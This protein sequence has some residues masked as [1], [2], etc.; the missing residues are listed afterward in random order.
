MIRIYL[1]LPRMTWKLFA[2][3]A[4][5][6]KPSRP[7]ANTPRSQ[8]R[9]ADTARWPASYR[10]Q[11]RPS[12]L[13]C[14]G[15]SASYSWDHIIVYLTL[16]YI[17]QPTFRRRQ[18]TRLRTALVCHR[19][20]PSIHLWEYRAGLYRSTGDSRPNLE[21]ICICSEVSRC[22]D[23]V[24]W[25]NL[26]TFIIQ[27]TVLETGDERNLSDILADMNGEIVASSKAK[28]KLFCLP[29]E[30]WERIWVESWPE[31]LK[32]R[33]KHEVRRFYNTNLWK[34]VVSVSF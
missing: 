12:L 10:L 27:G 23:S 22:L 11:P 30:R 33:L 32:I 21:T 24:M 18:S 14:L 19:P 5:R 17:D 9:P 20:I 15:R 7:R 31:I 6:M 26:G 29:E 34:E 28:S 8:R 4:S 25:H 2:V 16:L 3:I 1:N 13:S